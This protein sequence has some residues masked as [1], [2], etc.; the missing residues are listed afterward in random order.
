MKLKLYKMVGLEKRLIDFGV[1]AQ[2]HTYKEMGYVI[3]LANAD[4]TQRPYRI[5]KE[6]FDKVWYTLP[7]AEKHRL[8]DLPNDTDM[9]IEGRLS[10]LK[11]EI[12]TRCKRRITV[13]PRRIRRPSMMS[14]VKDFFQSLIPMEVCYA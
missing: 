4:D 7:A 2:A 11:A 10:S 1:V 3:E 14:M 8:S 13:V 5:V 9:S 12:A 6:E